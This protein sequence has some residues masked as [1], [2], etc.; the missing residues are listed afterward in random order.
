M[1]EDRFKQS[2]SKNKTNQQ[3]GKEE[4]SATYMVI[5]SRSFD[6]E[7]VNAFDLGK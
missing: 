7:G 6:L 4:Q 5:T 1:V 3:T 2:L